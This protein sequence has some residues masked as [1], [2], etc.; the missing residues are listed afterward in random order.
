[1]E[2]ENELAPIRVNKNPLNRFCQAATFRGSTSAI[3]RGSSHLA[4]PLA[5]KSTIIQSIG[6]IGVFTMVIASCPGY[7][8]IDRPNNSTRGAQ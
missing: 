7:L 5:D 1:M 3:Y 4:K 6:G 8:V 2:L